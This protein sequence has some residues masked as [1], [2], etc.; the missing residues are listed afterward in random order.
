VQGAHVSHGEFLA[1]SSN[2][3]LKKSSSGGCE[4][5]VINIE[6]KMST[7]RAILVCEQGGVTFASCKPNRLNEGLKPSELG[8]RG[9]FE[10]IER[11]VEL[12]DMIGI[13][14][15]NESR[16]LLTINCFQ[17]SA[18]EEGIF[19]VELMNWAILV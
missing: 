1:K 8:A 18:I 16:W 10:T 14:T 19:Y 9:L 6:K 12:A 7:P 4:H 2:N 5:C 15:V 17:E 13:V 3:L 11:P